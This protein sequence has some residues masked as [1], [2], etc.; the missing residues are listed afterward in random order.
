MAVNDTFPVDADY[1]V[2]RTKESNVLRGRLESAREFFRQKAAPRRIFVLVF[3]RRAKSDWDAIETFRLRML[4]D[5]FTLHDKTANRKYSVYFD[6]EPVYE[7][8]GNEEH[9]IRVQLIEAVGAA[10]LQYPAFATEPF[11]NLSVAQ[12]LDLGTN[13][14]QFLYA[15]YGFRVNGSFT[16]I[17]LDE[18]DV[19]GGGATKTDVALGLHR[20][21]V[22][23]GSP[24]SLDYL[25]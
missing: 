22:V 13:G 16:S 6:G 21:R 17:F 5:F 11:V 14:K 1:T 25:L 7:E 10:M 23:G 9:T 2:T 4:T 20:V 19:T 18:A 24:T 3:N 8:S 12:A 15:G